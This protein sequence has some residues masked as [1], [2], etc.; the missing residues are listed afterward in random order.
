WD[1]WE[2]ESVIDE[3]EVILKDEIPELITKF[4]N[5]DKRVPTIFDRARMEATLNDM[6]NNQFQNAVEY[7]YHLDQ[8]TNFMENQ[9]I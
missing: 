7:A 3:D 1:A 6:L 4:Q 5:V 2:E 8:A 9:I